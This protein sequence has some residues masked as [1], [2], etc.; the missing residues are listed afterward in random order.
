MKRDYFSTGEREKESSSLLRRCFLNFNKESDSSTLVTQEKKISPDEELKS[1]NYDHETN[2]TD[3]AHI[4]AG[5]GAELKINTFPNAQ[6]LHKVK[7]HNC[8]KDMNNR[9][10]QSGE[11]ETTGPLDSMQSSTLV[12]PTSLM[13]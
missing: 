5:D 2:C 10:S 3:Q 7:Q 8:L 12:K 6:S 4:E 11:D 9:R 1:E 13:K